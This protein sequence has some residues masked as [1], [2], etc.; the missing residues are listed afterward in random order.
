MAQ[1]DRAVRRATERAANV[2]AV[3]RHAGGRRLWPW[4]LI[5]SASAAVVAVVVYVARSRAAALVLPFDEPDPGSPLTTGNISD[6]GRAPVPT[7]P[8]VQ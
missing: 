7:E 3:R 1:L 8:S 4:L 6:N 5:G 2:D